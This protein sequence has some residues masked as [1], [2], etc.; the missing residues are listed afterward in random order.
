MTERAY[1][2][3]QPYFLPAR[4]YFNLIGT[5]DSF[6]FFD[7]AQF[8]R[9]G[10]VHRFETLSEAGGRTWVT[11]PIVKSSQK[12]EIRKITLENNWLSE[13][14]RRLA[15]FPELASAWNSHAPITEGSDNSLNLFRY[16]RGQIVGFSYALGFQTQFFNASELKER[17]LNESAEE[18]IIRLGREIDCAK[19]INLPGGV[20]LYSKEKFA[21]SGIVLSFSPEPTDDGFTILTDLK[22]GDITFGRSIT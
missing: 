9:R 16:L 3:M 15:K 5:V 1:A 2:V 21:A 4:R 8:P 13:F 6:V 11:L 14:R 12:T 7:N 19:Y 10:R 20:G 22:K 18:Y 17:A